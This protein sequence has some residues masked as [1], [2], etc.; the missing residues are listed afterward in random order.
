VI[1]GGLCIIFTAPLASSAWVSPIQAACLELGLSLVDRLASKGVPE[2]LGDNDVLLTSDVA[3]A[4]ALNAKS[5]LILH[6]YPAL[7]SELSVADGNYEPVRAELRTTHARLARVNEL[8]SEGW[9]VIDASGASIELGSLGLLHRHGS[10]STQLPVP[11]YD[12]PLAIFA[13]LPIASGQSAP[14]PSSIFSY[15]VGQQPEGGQPEIDLS[16]RGRIVVHGPYLPLPA[17]EW[18]VEINTEV[19]PETGT[20]YLRFEWGF[21]LDVAAV[22]YE[23]KQAGLYQ[24]KMQHALGQGSKAQIRVWAQRPTFDGRIKLVD[25]I[26]TYLGPPKA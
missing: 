15:T 21:D 1:S 16:G 11:T 7:E 8:A 3:Q 10:P 12:T 13:R 4:R 2:Q 9:P 18:A 25:C 23:T 22:Y 24:I 5:Y 17:G 14:W 19:D 6:D 20:A 26:L